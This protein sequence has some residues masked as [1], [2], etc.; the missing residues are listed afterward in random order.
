M[1]ALAGRC[2]GCRF[3]APVAATFARRNS[4]DAA[5]PHR[6]GLAFPRRVRS[7]QNTPENLAKLGT[8]T[9]NRAGFAPYL[10]IVSQSNAPKI[11][12][13]PRPRDPEN[14]RGFAFVYSRTISVFSVLSL[15]LSTL[16]N[17]ARSTAS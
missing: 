7:F 3:V 14:L 12:R 6:W 16:V 1:L 13:A 5:R 11:S 10:S 9:G 2:F 15:R 8:H 17:L 4:R